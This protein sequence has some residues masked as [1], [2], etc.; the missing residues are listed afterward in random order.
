METKRALILNT[1]KTQLKFL[2][3]I[4]RKESLENLILTGQIEG[5]W[6]TMSNLTVSLSKWMTD[7]ILS[8]DNKK[9]KNIKG[10]KG[11]EIVK[12]HDSL[13]S[14]RR[15]FADVVSVYHDIR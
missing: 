15:G 1:R 14:H 10:Y 9:I 8:R 3:H 6:K 5:Q 13:K 4:M 11:Q 12:S 7:Q 2:A